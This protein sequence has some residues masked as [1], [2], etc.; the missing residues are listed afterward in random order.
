M[1]KNSLTWVMVALFVLYLQ[2]QK[3]HTA[4]TN[5]FPAHKHMAV[6]GSSSKITI[7]LNVELTSGLKLNS[8]DEYWL[9][10]LYE[11]LG[12]EKRYEEWSIYHKNVF[13]ITFYDQGRLPSLW[14]ATWPSIPQGSRKG[15]QS[16]NKL[17]TEV[18]EAPSPSLMIAITR[19]AIEFLLQGF[20][21]IVGK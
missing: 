5:S 6:R 14:H 15:F 12:E 17:P 9:R 16:R 2:V 13:S 7:T 19:T 21:Q 8:S 10:L 20:Q 1:R 4:N 3:N 11:V 18:A